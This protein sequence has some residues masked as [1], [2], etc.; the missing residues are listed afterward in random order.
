MALTDSLLAYWKLDSANGALS[1]ADATGNNRPLSGSATLT[2]PGKLGT[3]CALI[4]TGNSAGLSRTISIIG[5]WSVAFWFRIES[6]WD[7]GGDPASIFCTDSPSGW[8]VETVFGDGSVFLKYHGGDYETGS[9]SFPIT[10]GTWYHCVVKKDNFS[11]DNG[12]GI[13]RAWSNVSL[14]IN[15]LRQTGTDFG[16]DDATTSRPF[17]VSAIGFRNVNQTTGSVSH[18][19]IGLWGRSLQPSEISALYNSGSGLSYYGPSTGFSPTAPSASTVRLVGATSSLIL[20][21]AGELQVD[22]T[23]VA[24]VQMEYSCASGYESTADA[25]LT[26][27]SSPSFPTGAQGMVLTGLK[28][29]RRPGIT[30]Y[31]V[32]YTGLVSPYYATTYGSQLQAYS[33]TTQTSTTTGTPPNQTTTTATLTWT[34]TYLSPTVTS[35]RISSNGTDL[36]DLPTSSADVQVLTRYLNGLPTGNAPQGLGSRWQL[37]EVQSTRVGNVYLM[38]ETA[39]KVLYLAY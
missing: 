4:A 8:N 22:A 19:E 32:T 38:K 24:T 35:Y 34:G 5:E 1:L 29:D 27:G 37:L 36:G 39:S 31:Q 9:V 20:S 13:G 26:F 15:G 25:T 14:W 2:S 23:G 33:F 18:D 6:D 28:K 10:P 7:T 11:D 16:Y 17:D 3:A 30:V 12:T 21:R